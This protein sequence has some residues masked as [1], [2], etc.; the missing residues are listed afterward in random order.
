M[1]HRVIDN[2]EIAALEDQGCF[3]S[4]WSKIRVAE[5][6]SAS[7]V[8]NVRFQGEVVVGKLGGVIST[9]RGEERISG[10]FNCKLT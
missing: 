10:L 1:N 3:S 5:N 6:F 2:S 4:D 7:Q 8:R 9:G